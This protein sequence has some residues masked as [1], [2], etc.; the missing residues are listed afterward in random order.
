VIE[1]TLRMLG[2]MKKAR[3]HENFFVLN[4]GVH[5]D[6]CFGIGESC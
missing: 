4:F 1:T 5:I 3:V 2:L 6:G